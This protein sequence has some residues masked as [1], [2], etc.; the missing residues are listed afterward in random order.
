[1]KKDMQWTVPDQFKNPETLKTYLN[2]FKEIRFISL[3]GIDFLGNDTDERIPVDYFI[4]N[5][6]D[7]FSGG[8]QTDGSSVNL[9]G[10]ATLNDAKIDFVIDTGSKWF[11]DHNFD[12]L[13]AEGKPVATVRIPIFFKHHNKFCC[14]RSVLKN[15]M[16]HVKKELTALIT[17][18][19]DFLPEPAR[20]SEIKDIEFTLG[21]ELE[22]WVRTAVDKVPA[23]DLE[24]SQMLKESYWKR[25]KG[26]VRT[27]LEEAL[28]VL[29]LYGFEPEMGHK[30][31]GGIKGKISADGKLFDVMEQLEINWKYSEPLTACDN[32]LFARI[33]IKE[34]FR[35][36]GLEATVVA[37]PV[38]GVAGSG[39]HMHVGMVAILKNGMKVNLFAPQSN[40]IFLSAAGYGALMGLLRNWEVVN[41]FV[42]H[43]NSALKRL[44]PGFEA[45]ISIAASLGMSPMS[46]SRNRSVLACL[47]RGEN[48]ASTRF[49]VRAPN[50]HTN[51]YLAMSAFLIAMLDGI[52]Y[53]AGKSAA[54]LDT[55]IH[56]KQGEPSGYLMKDREYVSE[57]DLFEDYTQ[58][59]RE[60]LFGKPPATVYEAISSIENTP[61]LYKNTPLSPSVIRSFYL[62]A[63]RKWEVEIVQKEIPAIIKDLRSI[64]RYDD[65]ENDLD[66]KTWESIASLRNLIAKD[67]LSQKSLVSRLKES[68]LKGDYV[69]A[70]SQFLELQRVYAELKE[71]TNL[72]RSN[73]VSE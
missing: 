13:T 65:L 73:M 1:M 3:V 18:N 25:T 15:T 51:S 11:V 7:I 21:T 53:S 6:T 40:D 31:V 55:E 36:S 58:A 52:K 46:P 70:S 24:V 60:S 48:P 17:A 43:S 26:Q 47:V 57:K 12:N 50:P 32:E 34:I 20:Y 61:E 42:T 71:V 41:P 59:E 33:V 30:E 56:K 28:E 23:R 67:S 66:Y 68:L 45:P 8:V 63:L 54:D 4:K 29:G 72:Y 62:S 14:S 64:R 37:K 16:N 2:N 35:R 5:M 22:F 19:R 44:K 38:E 49:E 39:E 27:C 10:I 9:P 69:R